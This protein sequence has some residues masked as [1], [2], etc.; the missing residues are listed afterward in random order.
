MSMYK[1]SD[2]KE[3]YPRQKELG[4]NSSNIDTRSFQLES[5]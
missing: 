1:N 2:F 4:N 5:L 3:T